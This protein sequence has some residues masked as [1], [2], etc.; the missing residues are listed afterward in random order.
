MTGT[1]LIRLFALLTVIAGVSTGCRT[2]VAPA[3]NKVRGTVAVDVSTEYLSTSQER[4]S[5][6]DFEAALTEALAARGL[7]VAEGGAPTVMITGRAS[8]LDETSAESKVGG[9]VPF[10]F[11]SGAYDLALVEIAS[12]REL[13]RVAG[14]LSI[15]ELKE[16]ALTSATVSFDESAKVIVADAA[17][18]IASQLVQTLW[19]QKRV[20]KADD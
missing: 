20:V 9:P 7:T 2:D 10:F 8:L 18:R 4:K 11:V 5:T 16:R 1:T 19:N 12:G 14:S 15:R 3:P 17:P 6:V 13:G